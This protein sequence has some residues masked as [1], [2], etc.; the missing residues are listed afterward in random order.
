MTS[1]VLILTLNYFQLNTH[2]VMKYSTLRAIPSNARRANEHHKFTCI[3]F[4]A[5]AT[6]R[7]NMIVISR[8]MRWNNEL[9]PIRDP[10]PG[11]V[12]SFFGERRL[13]D[14][15]QLPYIIHIIIIRIIH[16][17]CG[18]LFSVLN[19]IQTKI[20]FPFHRQRKTGQKRIFRLYLW[21]R[22][23]CH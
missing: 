3:S 22:Q 19:V 11:I 4:R 15:T 16:K 10:L 13:Y 6:M 20:T 2:F 5:F 14:V 23:K 1:L 18:S 12:R 9:I 17:F 8:A 7:L 21:K